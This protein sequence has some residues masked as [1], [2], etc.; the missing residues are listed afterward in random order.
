VIEPFLSTYVPGPSGSTPAFVVPTIPGGPTINSDAEDPNAQRHKRF[1]RKRSQGET[2]IE[3]RNENSEV[4][5]HWTTDSGEAEDEYDSNEDAN[6]EAP[7]DDDVVVR[8]AN[9]ADPSAQEV[10]RSSR[11]NN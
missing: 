8:D 1:K 7:E 4:E 11:L 9:A 10:R 5:G 2:T 3:L 6:D